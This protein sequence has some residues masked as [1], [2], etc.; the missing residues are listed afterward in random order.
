MALPAVVAALVAAAPT[1]IAVVNTAALFCLLAGWR[2]IRR[3]RV[4][5]HRA[6]MLAAAGCISFF[7]ILYVTRVSLGGVKAFPG[8]AAVRVYLYLPLL[9]VHIGLSVLSVPLVIH[10][11][12]IGLT[13]RPGEVPFTAHP[14]VGRWAVLLWS[15]SL[16]LGLVVYLLLNV[17]Y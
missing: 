14:R 2:A 8:P 12:V 15:I 10:N 4:R 5:A 7:L 3:G 6:L 16:V 17:L 11:L 9:T 1:I 13:Y